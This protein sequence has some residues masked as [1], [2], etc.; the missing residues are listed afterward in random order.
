MALRFC[1]DCGRTI[2]SEAHT[3]PHCGKPFG[4]HDKLPVSE[5]CPYCGAEYSLIRTLSAQNMFEV[6]MYIIMC[7]LVLPAI[8][9]VAYLSEAPYCIN[10][11]RRISPRKL[12][13]E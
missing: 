13:K 12:K 11:G 3:C 4:G 8:F 2:S 1:P 7:L 6:F 9:F 5:K 10:C